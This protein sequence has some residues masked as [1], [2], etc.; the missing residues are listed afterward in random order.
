MQTIIQV[1]AR[2]TK[3]LRDR[4][5]NDTKKLKEFELEVSEQ[6]RQDRAPG[7]AKIHMPGKRG[8]INIQWHDASRTLICWIVTRGGPPNPIAGAFTNYLLAGLGKRIQ[9]IQIIPD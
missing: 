3:S 1:V 7:W 6:K 5:V 8:A 2:E 4:I 9:S